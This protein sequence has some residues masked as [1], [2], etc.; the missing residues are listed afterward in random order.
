M[1]QDGAALGKTREQ[2][3]LKRRKWGDV[4]ESLTQWKAA[5]LTLAPRLITSAIDALLR[6]VRDSARG[7]VGNARGML[8]AHPAP[9]EGEKPVERP[10]GERAAFSEVRELVK[11]AL[12]EMLETAEYARLPAR[13]ATLCLAAARELV[14]ADCAL[15]QRQQGGLC[16]LTAHFC[17]ARE[18]VSE[19]LV[20]LARGLVPSSMVQKAFDA[21]LRN[22]KLLSKIE[23][24]CIGK[25]VRALIPAPPADA[26]V[27]AVGKQE[28]GGKVMEMTESLPRRDSN[29]SLGGAVWE[30]GGK[31]MELTDTLLRRVLETFE[32]LDGL[33]RD[34][35][36][37][38]WLVFGC[39]FI[40]AVLGLV[41]DT[42][43]SK[44]EALLASFMALE[45]KLAK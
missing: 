9:G 32:A 11:T 35:E 4:S 27:V 10:A 12:R 40:N 18:R 16:A 3:A 28:L 26:S 38:G 22:L 34:K 8:E 17:S 41:G 19:D 39:G 31:V 45:S 37:M 20:A 1:P 33:G 5:G 13:A 24:L 15:L 2:L 43:D 23:S 21:S 36:L 25:G 42:K 6:A 14:C 29:D 7:V 44:V 30:L